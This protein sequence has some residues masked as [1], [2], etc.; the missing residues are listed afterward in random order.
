MKYQT[1]TQPCPTIIG[2]GAISV[3]GEEITKRGLKKPMLVFDK[4]VKE[5]GIPE[6]VEAYLT[7]AGIEFA[8]FGGVQPD[9][10]VDVVDACG[11][12]AVEVGADCLIGVGGGSSM[13]TAKAT[14]IRLS[15]F[16]GRARDY[17]LQTPIFVNTTTPVFLIPTTTGTGSENTT[18]AII[19][20]PEKNVKWSVNVNTTLAIVDP[21]LT[22]TLPKLYTATTGLDALAHATEGITSVDHN[23]QADYM[24]LGAVKKIAESLVNCY[25]NPTDI[26]AR[27]EMAIAANWGGLAF[28][29]PLT[30]VSH[31]I[32]DALGCHFHT[33]H[34]LSCSLGL[35]DTLRL[36]APVYPERIRWIAEAMGCKLT[37]SET[38]EELGDIVAEEIFKMMRAMDM[39]SLKSLGCTRE[40]IVA[41]AKEVTE[42]HLSNHCP[43]KITL[44]VAEKL[45][46]DVYDNYQ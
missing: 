30:H 5:A 27:T 13:D 29:N 3:I 9:P 20:V 7:A 45:L 19:S 8:E 40:E 18:V 42:N 2:C 12:R 43:V 32:G 31:A 46:G 38:G 41:C 34:G 21:E 23:V 35:A 44:E 6:K 4:G 11:D 1:Y 17:V 36:V 15:G 22:V 39:P 33:P 28:N 25:N 26:N 16:E 37:G 10:S 24:G 14:T